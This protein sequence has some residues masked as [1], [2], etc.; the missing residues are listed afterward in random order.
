MPIITREDRIKFKK[1]Y[2]LHFR[3]EET[4]IQMALWLAQCTIV[5][6]YQWNQ[7]SSDFLLLHDDISS[8]MSS[9]SKNRNINIIRQSLIF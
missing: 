1:Q 6:N 3:N 2:E 5:N 7:P 4:E 9:Q 8:Q